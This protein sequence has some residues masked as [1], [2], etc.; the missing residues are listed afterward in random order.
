MVWC[1]WRIP[2]IPCTPNSRKRRNRSCRLYQGIII[3]H[4]TGLTFLSCWAPF[5]ANDS[6]DFLERL[7]FHSIAPYAS[8]FDC[9]YKTS[10]CWFCSTLTGSGRTTRNIQSERSSAI[11]FFLEP[12]AHLGFLC[13][14]LSFLTLSSRMCDSLCNCFF[15]YRLEN[16][17]FWSEKDDLYFVLCRSS[18]SLPVF[19][20]L[21]ESKYFMSFI[22]W[23]SKNTPSKVKI[24]Q[25]YCLVQAVPTNLGN[26]F[27]NIMFGI[28]VLSW[29]F[30]PVRKQIKRCNC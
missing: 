29:V 10:V 22:E 8:I 9:C 30:P 23:Y 17:V 2:G 26:I 21:V 11:R 5:S 14:D 24:G 13:P 20:K 18:G 28:R 15:S 12:H 4:G 19:E 25:N 16:F 1:K 6:P 3:K 27:E 7:F